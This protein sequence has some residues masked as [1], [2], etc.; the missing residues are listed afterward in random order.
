VP[1]A[2]AIATPT[3]AAIASIVAIVIRAVVRM[4][5]AFFID[6][7]LD[8]ARAVVPAGFSTED[9]G[10]LALTVAEDPGPGEEVPRGRMP[11]T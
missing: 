4:P 9:I 2:S 1:P 7:L 3:G 6:R 10:G 8:L 5:R 11:L